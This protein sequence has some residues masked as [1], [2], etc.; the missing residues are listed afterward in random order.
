M[1]N[2]G[3]RRSRGVEEE[4]SYFVSMADMMVGLVFVFLILLLYFAL[5]FRQET[6]RLDTTGTR[7]EILRKLKEDLLEQGVVV[8]IDTNTGVLRLPEEILF[9]QGQAMLKPEGIDKLGKLRRVMEA[10]LPCYTYPR[11]L[12]CPA[13][14]HHLDAIFVEGHTDISPMRGAIDNLDLSVQRATTTYRVLLPPG[15]PLTR[16]MNAPGAGAQPVFSVSGYG[17]D[18]PVPGNDGIDPV[19]LAKNRRIDLRFLMVTPRAPEL[20]EMLVRP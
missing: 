5:Q 18:R 9:D 8:K 16:L 7:A 10:V 19:S 1:A 20:S 6:T 15:S 11:R 2:G 17:P 3:V 13:V 4:E 14:A 12:N